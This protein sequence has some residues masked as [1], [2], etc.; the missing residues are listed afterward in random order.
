MVGGVIVRRKVYQYSLKME[1]SIS[2]KFFHSAF[3]SE[4][5]QHVLNAP[6][7]PRPRREKDRDYPQPRALRPKAQIRVLAQRYF[8]VD[9]YFHSCHKHYSNPLLET[10]TEPHTVFIVQSLA[11]NKAQQLNCVSTTPPH[12]T[13]PQALQHLL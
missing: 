4:R 12:L 10:V 8:G 7:V 6:P 9:I 11:L 3:L 5:G 2:R 1:M 13:T